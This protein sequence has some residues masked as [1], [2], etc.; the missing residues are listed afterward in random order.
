MQKISGYI[1]KFEIDPCGQD[2]QVDITPEVTEGDVQLYRISVRY[3]EKT[4]PGKIRIKWLEPFV[5]ILSC[6]TPGG[7]FDRGLNADWRPSWSHSRSAAGAPIISLTGA[8][9][10]N[11]CTFA[12]SVAATPLAM[13]EG[14]SEKLGDVWCVLELSTNRIDAC[15]P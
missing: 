2:V 14:V 15:E 4:V 9:G 7:R 12:V 10:D 6:W 11:S 13:S 1:R 3:P 5:D 8:A